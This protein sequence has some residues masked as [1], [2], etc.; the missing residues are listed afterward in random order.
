MARQRMSQQK[1]RENQMSK[2]LSSIVETD[3]KK[4]PEVAVPGYGTMPLDMLKR[5][6][7]ELSKDFNVLIQ[8][9]AFLK[10]TYRTEQFYNALMALAKALKQQGMNENK[11]YDELNILTEGKLGKFGA[12]I[13]GASA[14]KMIEPEQNVINNVPDPLVFGAAGAYAGKKIYDKYA[15]APIEPDRLVEPP[16]GPYKQPNPFKQEVP[17]ITDKPRVRVNPSTGS[18]E[19]AKTKS[20]GTRDPKTGRFASNKPTPNSSTSIPDAEPGRTIGG[21]YKD[22]RWH[23]QPIQGAGAAADADDVVRGL[24]KIPVVGKKLAAGAAALG[25]L[26]TLGYGLYKGTEPRDK[27][28]VKP[29]S[30]PAVSP[31]PPKQKSDEPFGF[32]APDTQAELDAAN[33]PVPPSSE[34][35]LSPEERAEAEAALQQYRYGDIKETGAVATMPPTTMPSK[36]LKTV[37]KDLAKKSIPA[38]GAAFYGPEIKDRYKKGD[39]IGA[40]LATA[41]A[42]LS[43]LPGK[44]AGLGLVPDVINMMRDQNVK[45]M[46]P[47]EK[48][49][50]ARGIKEVSKMSNKK[51]LENTIQNIADLN[52]IAD[53][54]K[55]I[56][57]NQ[58]TLPN[59]KVYLIKPGDTL[60]QIALDYNRGKLPAVDTTSDEFQDQLERN[61]QSKI[62]KDLS[63]IDNPLPSQKYPDSDLPAGQ[64]FVDQRNNPGNLRFF[65][66][67][68]RPGYVLDKAIGVDKNG[69]AVFATPED[70]LNA[71]RR[72]IA[73]DTQK[74]GLTGRQLINK[75]APAADSNQPDVYVKNIFGQLGIDPDSK[76]DPKDIKKIQQL[77]VRQEHGKEGMYHYYPQLNPRNTTAN[78]NEMEILQRIL[79]R[80]K[81]KDK[82]EKPVGN[83]NAVPKKS[84][85]PKEPGTTDYSKELELDPSIP[86]MHPLELERPKVDAE[87]QKRMQQLEKQ[88]PVKEIKSSI[89]KGII[90]K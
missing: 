66:N 70:G 12:A 23:Q 89:M 71:M 73:L 17:S 87:V 55:I 39:Y 16:P 57:G 18:F 4:N 10:A 54:N 7:Q 15:N 14:G 46:G 64:E 32:I 51:M 77:M 79:D 48:S 34:P 29:T 72:Q 37:A 19:P 20:S 41:G 8:Q 35:E 76:I 40:A 56:A 22:M 44:S 2:I 43:L 62:E 9:G 53:I 21:G 49:P 33:T 82:Q 11:I 61:I 83:P 26:G 13:A 80:N 59:Q 81:E 47:D 45:T 30:I 75:Y 25:T 58:L 78:L 90:S 86:R 27:T 60:S 52:K 24:S 65:K 1:V 31:P 74:R 5:H 28:D 50:I 88:K 3:L 85:E 67:L 63:Q 6:V 84:T 38:A 36:S 69:F 42:G 68:N